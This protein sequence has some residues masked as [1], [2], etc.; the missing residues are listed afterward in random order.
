MA[1]VW[2]LTFRCIVQLKHAGRG[3]EGGLAL[4]EP[5]AQFAELLGWERLDGFFDF[6]GGAHGRILISRPLSFKRGS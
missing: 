6:E 3:G 5:L 4:G 2:R 1:D